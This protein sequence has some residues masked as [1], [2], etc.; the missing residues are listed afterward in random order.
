MKRLSVVLALSIALAIAISSVAAHA[1]VVYDIVA[2]PNVLKT[3]T[4][5][6][7][8]TLPSQYKLD[9]IEIKVY[10]LYGQLVATVSE[11]DAYRVYW[12]GGGLAN[13]VYLYTARYW[14][15]DGEEE[16]EDEF[17]PYVLYISK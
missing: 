2:L 16:Q 15:Y 7:A 11:E 6:T 17:G 14:N 1:V 12:T 13:G 10:N 3:Y 4:Y 5:F 8:Q 9:L